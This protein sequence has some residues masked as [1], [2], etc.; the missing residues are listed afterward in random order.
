MCSRVCRT[1]DAEDD[2]K[3]DETSVRLAERIY[4]GG[5]SFFSGKAEMII[6]YANFMIDVSR[7][8]AAGHS[9]LVAAKN[10]KPTI[11]QQVTH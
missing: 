4:K 10:L 2:E 8:A 11:V 9:Q 6:L 1:P 7:Q 5:M 3:Q